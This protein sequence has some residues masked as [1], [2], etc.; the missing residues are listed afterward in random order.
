MT[1][2]LKVSKGFSHSF[3]NGLQE[4]RKKIQF[5]NDP[6]FSFSYSL[7]ILNTKVY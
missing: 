3:L 6:C 5:N 2:K 7:L 4:I 1:R